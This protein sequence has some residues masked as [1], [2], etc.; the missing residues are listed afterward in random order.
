MP[1]FRKAIMKEI[2]WQKCGLAVPKELIRNV[3]FKF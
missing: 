1:F 3:N 2:L